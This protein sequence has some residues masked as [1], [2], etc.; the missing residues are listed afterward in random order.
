MDEDAQ[1]KD[2]YDSMDHDDKYEISEDIRGRNCWQGYHKCYEIEKE[3]ELIG[4]NV[5]RIK[6]DF[7]NCVDEEMYYCEICEFKNKEMTK[8]Q[9][10]FLAKHKE[11][12][13]FSCWECATKV[14]TIDEFKRHIGNKHYIQQEK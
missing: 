4:V 1:A 10:H 2:K 12:H 7:R 8:V 5:R 3:N 13:I 9:D 14:K 11:S 6:E